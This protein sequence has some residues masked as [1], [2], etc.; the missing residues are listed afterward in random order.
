MKKRTKTTTIFKIYPADHHA[1]YWW[2]VRDECT[3]GASAGVRITYR[4]PDRPEELECDFIDIVA[5]PSVLRSIAEAILRKADE[6]EI[7]E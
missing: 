5:E 2:E 7:E 6:Q 3:L 4:Q 1:D